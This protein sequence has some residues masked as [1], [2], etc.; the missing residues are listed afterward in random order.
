MS[1]R[2]VTWNL[3]G[4]A[5]PDLGA[6]AAHLREVGA[7]VVALQ[8][9][10]RSQARRLAVRA[11][12]P[13]RDLELQALPGAHLAGGHGR[14]RR[15]RPREGG[16]ARVVGPVA[17]RGA[18]AGGSS[19][20]PPSPPTAT[21]GRATLV[22]VH[23]STGDMGARRSVELA[24]VVEVIDA[25]GLP[26]I[27]AGD[28]NDDPDSALFKHM[29]ASGLHDTWL[30]A[31]PGS[32][33]PDG[34]TNW[35]GWRR[36]TQEAA[37]PPHR[38]RGRLRRGGGRGAS[39][40]P[41]SASRA[42]RC[43][44]RCPTTF[45]SPPRWASTRHRTR[46]RLRPRD[47]RLP[48]RERRPAGDR[49]RRQRAPPSAGDRLSR[50]GRWV[51]V[52]VTVA[53]CGL[54]LAGTAL[55]PGRPLPVRAVPHVR[56]LGQA[57]RRR[58]LR[59]PRGR[60]RGRRAVQAERHVHRAPPGRDRG[61][62]GPVPG[63]RAA[64][65]GRRRRLRRPPS[66]RAPACA[67]RDPPAPLPTGGRRAVRR[68]DRA[69]GRG[70]GRARLRGAGRL[71]RP[72][73]GRRGRR[74]GGRR[75]RRSPRRPP[76]PTRAARRAPPVRPPGR[77]AGD[78]HRRHAGRAGNG[79]AAGPAPTAVRLAGGAGPPRPGGRLPHP[80]L[81]VRPRSTCCC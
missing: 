17:A 7:D 5:Q 13:L 30:V 40:S 79:P 54:L 56:P 11:R 23:F 18:G 64:P 47:R 14:R 1:L 51:R 81:P 60:E 4:S 9:V 19:R 22:N 21:T 48:R 31:H 43:S 65:R 66:R 59:P 58:E 32:V 61:A 55:G 49:R 35:P 37:D 28:T 69:P 75:A 20:P 73:R 76:R 71:R 63:R 77:R 46:D 74:R 53:G 27:L 62:D 34:A 44:R 12:R 26:G 70:V 52:V 36:N 29:A 45:P 68:G 2:V 41:A 15:H 8:E 80:G 57:R 25:A 3:K 24:E 39:P 78:R 33:E 72:G 67:R 16:G 38:R 50:A 10:Q 42:S 6:V